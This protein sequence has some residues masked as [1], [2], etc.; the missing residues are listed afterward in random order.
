MKLNNLGRAAIGTI[1]SAAAIFGLTACSRDYTVAYLYSTSAKG[2]ASGNGAINAYRIDYQSGIPIQLEDSPVAAQRNPV[3]IVATSDNKNLY[4]VNNGSSSIGWYAIGS[5]GKIYI[6]QTYNAFQAV[7]S[8]PTWAAIDNTGK[9]LFVTFTYQPGYTTSIP[10][11]GALGVFPINADGSLGSPVR[12]GSLSYFPVGNTPVSVVTSPLPVASPLST[13]VY[14]LDQEPS[15]GVVLGFAENASTGVLSA[16]SGTTITTVNATTVATGY[17]AGTT[18]SAMVED[19]ASKY[20]YVTDQA[21][22]QVLGY[23]VSQTGTTSGALTPIVSS[24]YG[25]GLFPVAIAIEPRNQFMYVANKSAGTVNVYA[26][27]SNGALTGSAGG[28]SQLVGTGPTCI[29]IEGSLGK[30]LYTTDS[31][32]NMI[33]GEQINANTGALTSIENTPFPASGLPTC[34]VA[35]S[36]GAAHATQYVPH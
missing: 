9:F 1:L 24:P 17:A 23:Q 25:T 28:T 33:S 35:V 2:D 34:A 20:V 22:N 11:P 3:S 29:A 6:Q 7:G 21:A 15:H 5:D 12:N 19:L 10:G 8:L 18:P 16:T 36:S 30:Y 13:Y 32:Q 26:F 31:L 14:V 4:V 27:A